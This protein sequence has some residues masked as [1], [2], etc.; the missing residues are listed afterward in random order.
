MRPRLGPTLGVLIASLACAPSPATS[1]EPT[2]AGA[3]VEASASPERRSVRP[4]VND[5][6]FED[7]A[8]ERWTDTLERERREVIALRDPIVAA[9]ELEPGMVV[10]DIGAG[11]GAFMSALSAGV[12]ETGTVYAVDIVPAFLDHLRAR[13]ETEGLTKVEVVEATPTAVGLAD[14]SVDLMFMCDVYHH[15]EYP[16]V[17]VRSLYEALRPEGRLIIVE[18][19][20]IPGETSAKMMKHVRQDQATLVAEVTAEGF[21]LE[22]EIEDVPFDENYMLVFRK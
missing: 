14:A 18:F 17:Y 19:D 1:V 13:A 12:G 22:R 10:A 6:Y 2:A 3:G 4:G 15:I 5:R 9:L 11:T 16:S 21:V 20:R 7:G 8:V